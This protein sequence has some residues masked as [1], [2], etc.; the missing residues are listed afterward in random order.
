MHFCVLCYGLAVCFP[1]CG[2]LIVFFFFFF[3]GLIA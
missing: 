3:F 1:L 2:D